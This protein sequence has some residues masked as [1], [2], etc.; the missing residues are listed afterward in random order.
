M[1]FIRGGL[2]GEEFIV[3]EN[4]EEYSKFKVSFKIRVIFVELREM[5]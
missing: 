1:L 5:N 4:E 2:E 3:V